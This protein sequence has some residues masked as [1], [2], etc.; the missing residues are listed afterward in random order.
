MEPGAGKALTHVI[1]PFEYMLSVHE[2]AK[3]NQVIAIRRFPD[4]GEEVTIA[5]ESKNAGML[6]VWIASESFFPHLI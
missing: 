5:L 2:E 4:F 1:Y 6:V 3:Q